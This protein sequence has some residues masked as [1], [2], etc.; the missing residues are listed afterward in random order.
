MA[1]TQHCLHLH[2]LQK[3]ARE[4]HCWHR[5]AGIDSIPL[6]QRNAERWLQPQRAWRGACLLFPTFTIPSDCKRR[7]R[8]KVGRKQC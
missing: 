5:Q 2:L 1:K 7:D 6:L 8:R 3:L 4:D